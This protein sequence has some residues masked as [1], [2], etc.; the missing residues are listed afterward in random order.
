MTRPR[1]RPDNNLSQLGEE[2]WA[3]AYSMAE[4]V[5]P[6]FTAD[7]IIEAVREKSG[8]LLNRNNITTL[9]QIVDDN[10]REEKRLV[11][12]RA[13]MAHEIAEQFGVGEAGES[14]LREYLQGA[15][16]ANNTNLRDMDPDK[17]ARLVLY[18]ERTKI[19]RDKVAADRE[20]TAAQIRKLEAELAE[21][22]RRIEEL[23]TE[24][25]EQS[26]TFLS[27]ASK[28]L[29]ILKTYGDLRPLLQKY[30]SNLAKRLSIEAERFTA[31]AA[32]G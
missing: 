14:L 11:E 27:T 24:G 5:K 26:V 19:L 7:R 2:A 8:I 25:S 32:H 31:G 12:S 29:E 6:R 28:V 22:E 1:L 17:V 10:Q 21:R 16:L 20:R 30:E 18:Q 9:W 23:R 4:S 15:L 3:L 13:I